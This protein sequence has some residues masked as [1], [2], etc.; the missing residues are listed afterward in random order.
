MHSQT[1]AL[2]CVGMALTMIGVA[3]LAY[4]VYREYLQL[5]RVSRMRARTAKL[6]QELRAGCPWE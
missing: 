5:R 3:P 1:I 2:L 4:S 6:N